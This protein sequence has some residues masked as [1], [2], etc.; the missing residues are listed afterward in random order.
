[1]AVRIVAKLPVLWFLLVAGKGS[2]H[3]T[4]FSA[5]SKMS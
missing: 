5:K 4:P 3:V 1:L 2:D